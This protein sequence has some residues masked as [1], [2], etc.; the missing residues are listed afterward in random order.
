MD[1][2]AVVVRLPEEGAQLIGDAAQGALRTLHDEIGF[3]GDP[4]VLAGGHAPAAEH[5]T[6]DMRAVRVRIRPTV[7]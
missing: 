6:G 1:T 2:R 7:V 3:I 5:R 4:P